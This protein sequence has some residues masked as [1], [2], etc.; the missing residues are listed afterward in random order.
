MDMVHYKA[1]EIHAAPYQLADS[2]EWQ[3]NLHIFRHRESESKSRNFSAG[4]S[5]KTL[6]EAV[7]HSVQLGKQ[8]IDGQSASCSVADL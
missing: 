2:G 3:V 7:K 5:Y 6:E 4:N 8:I 1:F